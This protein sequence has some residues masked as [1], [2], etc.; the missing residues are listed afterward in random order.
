MISERLKRFCQS[1]AKEEGTPFYLIDLD[2][3]KSAFLDFQDTCKNSFKHFRLAYSYKS[4]ALKA[5]TQ[6]F[7]ALG[8]SAEVVSETE[9]DWAF[10]DGFKPENIFFDG[11]LKTKE[12]LLLAIQ[13]QVNIQLDS[14][15][16]VKNL[17]KI[18]ESEK[19]S[20]K[21]SLRLA[22][23]YR[24]E[25]KSR[26]G[27][28]Y[29]EAQQAIHLFKCANIKL[30]GLHFHLGSNLD[31]P[32]LFTQILEE[33]K[34]IFYLV[35]KENQDRIWLDIGGGF[36]AKSI[37]KDK[38]PVPVKSFIMR[39]ADFIRQCEIDFDRIELIAEPGRCLVEDYGYLLTS[40][41]SKKK[42]GENNLLIVDA[43]IH[44]LKS[45]NTWYHPISILTEDNR[46]LNEDCLS[47]SIYGC[48]C[49]ENDVFSKSFSSLIELDVGDLIVM[50]SAGGYDIYSANAWTRPSPPILGILEDTICPLRLRQTSK[51]VR[52]LQTNLEEISNKIK[53]RLVNYDL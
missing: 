40:V 12:N 22:A 46:K 4:N 37:G 3:I 34:D 16:E 13:R 43:G 2:R 15:E 33:Y 39:V 8:S 31:E 41:S 29:E 26:F 11:P 35:L 28:T 42:R 24:V 52:C 48:N 6:Q 25:S 10:E 21:V 19:I 30:S 45:I 5:I 9:L 20:T 27:F 51:H 36:P 7:L 47:Y 53:Y 32:L 23:N 49:F 38:Q 14:L 17:I 50:G 18:F 44:L 1:A